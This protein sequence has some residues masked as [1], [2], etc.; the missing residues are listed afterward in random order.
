LAWRVKVTDAHT[1]LSHSLSLFS[2]NYIM[3][4]THSKLDTSIPLGCLLCSIRN[5]GLQQDIK[6]RWLIYYC[7]T[8]WPQYK[9]DNQSQWPENGTFDFHTLIDFDNFCH[10]NGKWSKI[11]YV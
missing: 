5:I 11:P 9:L 8:V 6:P 7:N 4:T 10:C 3:G 2:S 1:L